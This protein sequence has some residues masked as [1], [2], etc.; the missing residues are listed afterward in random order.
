MEQRILQ[1]FL[2]GLSIGS[3]Y[4]LIAVGYSL[5]YSILQFSNFAHGSFLV[6][7]AYVGFYMLAMA[8]LPLYLSLPL[9]LV[10]AG[11]GAIVTEKLAYSPIRNRGGRALYFIIASMGVSI[12]VENLIIVT[13]GPQFRT[14]PQVL[15]A[16]TVALGRVNVG[17]LDLLA[18]V[19][20]IACLIIL[21]VII[22]KTKIGIA[23][24]AASF[25]LR[26]AGLMGVNVNALIALVF[27]IAGSL[28]GLSGFFLG[29]KYTVYPQLGYLTLKAFVGAIFGGLGSLSGAIVGSVLLGLME[30]FIAGFVSSTLRDLFV[31]FLL[32]LVLIVKPSGLMGKYVEEKV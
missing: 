16:N 32:I 19:F 15:A 30:A 31:F 9:A 1:Q 17:V 14:Y 6:A 11:L 24:R 10:F 18:A 4:A 28:A 3:I 20:S 25:D 7:G 12:F 13:I 27:F 26:A 23:I 22:Q 5:I 8:R 21:E 2:N 29:M